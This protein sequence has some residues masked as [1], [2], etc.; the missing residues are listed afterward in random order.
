MVL[1][2][3]NIAEPVADFVYRRDEVVFLDVHVIGVQVDHHIVRADTVGQPQTIA[4]GVDNDYI[5]DIRRVDA[6]FA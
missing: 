5:F 6:Q 2:D 4:R 1:A 3:V